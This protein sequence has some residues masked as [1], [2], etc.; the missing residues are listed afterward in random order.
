MGHRK[1]LSCCR[2]SV[3]ASSASKAR[4]CPKRAYSCSSEPRIRTFPPYAERLA[5]FKAE[6]GVGPSDTVHEVHVT[7]A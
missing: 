5:A 6:K 4:S 7:F 1:D 3:T 2:V